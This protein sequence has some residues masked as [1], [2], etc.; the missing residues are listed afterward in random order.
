[1]TALWILVCSSS[2]M[3]PRSLL[4]FQSPSAFFDYF[5]YEC[6]FQVVWFE[7]LNRLLK[8]MYSVFDSVVLLI[9]FWSMFLNV[10]MSY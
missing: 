5:E 3:T 8:F 7:Y 1:M 9:V 2:S 10:A 4:G 6:L